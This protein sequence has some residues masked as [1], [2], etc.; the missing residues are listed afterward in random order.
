[1]SFMFVPPDDDDATKF[2]RWFKARLDAAEQ[3]ADMPPTLG[4]AAQQA[5]P[6]LRDALQ[7]A[8]QAGPDG[9]SDR[10]VTALMLRHRP[11]R[12]VH[13]LR[14]LHR[15]FHHVETLAV[16]TAFMQYQAS[17]VE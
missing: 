11:E 14:A 5:L 12:V 15:Y 7:L 4:V 9:D 3:E 13:L 17:Q 1:M 10:D 6:I 2:A 8:E 16:R